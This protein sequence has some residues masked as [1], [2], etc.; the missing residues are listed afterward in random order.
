MSEANC[1]VSDKVDVVIV[2]NDSCCDVGKVDKLI[3]LKVFDVFTSK[4]SLVC[5]TKQDIEGDGQVGT[6][7]ESVVGAKYSCVLHEHFS[8]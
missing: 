5:G 3:V 2:G 7:V 4:A 8:G 1:V 6:I